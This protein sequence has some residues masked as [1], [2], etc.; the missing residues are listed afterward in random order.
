MAEIEL[1]STA[2]LLTFVGVLLLVGVLFSRI[3]RRWPRLGIPSFLLFMAVGMLAGSEGP[4]G[5]DFEDYRLSFRIG[6]VALAL[7]LF[8]GGLNTSLAAFRRGLAPALTLATVGVAGTAALVAV[9]ARLLGF[10]WPVAFLIGAVI[11][12]TDAAAVFSVL[13]G[14]RLV[15]RE[16]VGATLELESGLNDPM[17]VL[18]TLALT[19][20]LAQGQTAGLHLLGDVVAQLALGTV[21]G[22]AAGLAGRALLRWS[23]LPAGG[24]YPVLTLAVALVAFG[25]PTLWNG[26]GFLAVYLAGVVL[27]NSELPYQTGLRRFHDALA[28]LGQVVLFLMLGLLSFPSR[29]L[30]AAGNGVTLALLAAFV[31]RP[32]VVALCLAPFRF[33]LRDTLFVGWVGLRG[34]VPILLAIFPVLGAVPGSEA[35]FDVVFCVVVV[36]AFLPGATVAWVARRLGIA[37]EGAPPPEAL[38]EISSLQPLGAQVVTYFVEPALPVCGAALADIPFPPGASVML[39]VR[40]GTLVAP[41]GNVILEP[42]DH[43]HTISPAA[44]RPFLDLLFGRAQE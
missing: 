41:R 32:L 25:L 36:G 39:I 23:R 27:G 40:G 7:I 33:R 38:L 28:W 29:I 18:L 34:A 14:S 37:T 21:F 13:R 11:S 10:P 3:S 31:A 16:R 9:G 5:I 12:S 20:S 4:G 2:G 15:L 1:S 8:D 30:G 6:T 22:G 24:L 26:S 19:A 42:G 44:D 43:V 35:V 17:A